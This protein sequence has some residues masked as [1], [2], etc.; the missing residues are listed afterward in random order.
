MTLLGVLEDD[1]YLPGH[2][3]LVIRDRHAPDAGEPQGHAL[4]G[5]LATDALSGTI[6]T[7]GDGWVHGRAGDPGQAV[8]L[9][10]HDGPPRIALAEWEDVVET[11]FHSR[12]GR[13][14]FADLTG[15]EDEGTLE[16]GRR[17]LFRA[18][19]AR[20]AAT[21]GE[22]GDVW[23]LQFWPCADPGLPRWVRR[24]RPA[25]GS[26]D[27]GWQLVL[28]YPVLEVAHFAAGYGPPPPESWLDEPLRGDPPDAALCAQLGG[29]PPESP[30]DAI[31]LLVAAG[32]LVPD[33]TRHR[34]AERP[35]S[36]AERLDLPGR[37]ATQVER[38]AAHTRYCRVAA[39]LTSVAAWGHPAPV[40]DLAERL[41]I[42][43]G[44]VPGLLAYATTR[45]VEPVEGGIVA[46]PRLRS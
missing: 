18:R 44:E 32:V 6:A 28:G 12:T 9:E 45:Y 10:A 29:T 43:P 34:F 23:L 7:A 21:D 14:A 25:I 42:P 24:T 13:L 20:R 4:L 30:R 37:L 39:D 36:A 8:R 2:G 11:P 3:V 33:G 26:P 22:E 19:I 46:R 31:E 1:E 5:E 40:D 35:P 27:P 38:A 15:G 41:L 17:G 16:L